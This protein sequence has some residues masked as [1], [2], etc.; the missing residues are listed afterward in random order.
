MSLQLLWIGLKGKTAI[1]LVPKGARDFAVRKA[2]A[3]AA[4]SSLRQLLLPLGAFRVRQRLCLWERSG[5]ASD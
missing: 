5:L 2:K 1:E 4:G 3:I